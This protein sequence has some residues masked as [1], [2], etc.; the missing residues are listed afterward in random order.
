MNAR[1]AVVVV[2]HVA[3]AAVAFG[4]ADDWTLLGPSGG[5]PPARN[6]H[7]MAAAGDDRALLFGGYDTAVDDESW[8]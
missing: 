5:P 6:G 7:A 1:L 2:L 8:V 3:G 4:S